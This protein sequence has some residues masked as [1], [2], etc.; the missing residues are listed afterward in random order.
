LVFWVK[1]EEGRNPIRE[2][3][4]SRQASCDSQTQLDRRSIQRPDDFFT[5]SPPHRNARES[6]L[7]NNISGQAVPEFS[8]NG[9]DGRGSGGNPS[10]LI[11]V[12]RGRVIPLFLLCGLL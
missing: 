7:A 3:G 6:V 12:I 2:Q 10:A 9:A 11:R 5:I 1:I 4:G 8:A